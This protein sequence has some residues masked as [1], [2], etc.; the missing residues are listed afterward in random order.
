MPG[1]LRREAECRRAFFARPD[2]RVSEPGLGAARVREAE[3]VRLQQLV[4]NRATTQL[5]RRGDFFPEPPIQRV[6]LYIGAGDIGRVVT[7]NDYHFAHLLRGADPPPSKDHDV[8]LRSFTDFDGLAAAAEAN[9][10][11]S[12]FEYDGLEWK[13][14]GKEKGETRL[15]LY[16]VANERDCVR[17]SFDV[18]G[19]LVRVAGGTDVQVG[20]K[21]DK[22]AERA[23]A[24]VSRLVGE[25]E[26]EDS[27]RQVTFPFVIDLG[28]RPRGL[29][30]KAGQGDG[31]LWGTGGSERAFHLHL[32]YDGETPGDVKTVKR[33][34]L[35][36]RSGHH[37]LPGQTA[38]GNP[39]HE[40]DLYVL[41]ALVETVRRWAPADGDD[42][43][44]SSEGEA[45]TPVELLAE[46][47]GSTTAVIER[48][49]K[50]LG[51]SEQDLDSVAE[52]D[53]AFLVGAL[54]G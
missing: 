46:R 17:L 26:V 28:Q 27:K 29:G 49:M 5:I 50:D 36:T 43:E 24:A 54:D 38:A 31:F 47:F 6:R 19:Q 42:V 3:A 18:I 22:T 44:K 4:G 12:R 41:N 37:Y 9:F 52:G 40:R 32:G 1:R 8:L 48:I 10:D 15:E 14:K 11:K 39:E 2:R 21:G 51:Y 35:K 53:F 30:Y 25:G 13:W 33:I 23:R 34:T 20:E 16:P 7:I 45:P